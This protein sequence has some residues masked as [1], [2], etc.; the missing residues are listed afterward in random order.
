MTV[1]ASRENAPGSPHWAPRALSRAPPENAP[2]SRPLPPTPPAKPSLR[3]KP[4]RPPVAPR[5]DS[6]ARG[7][8]LVPRSTAHLLRASLQYPAFAHT[9]SRQNPTASSVHREGQ[10]GRR[11]RAPA[12]DDRSIRKGSSRA[13]PARLWG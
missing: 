1:S 4:A 3:R 6:P 9:P 5:L 2:N 12:S 8:G 13:P 7:I 11:L 10:K